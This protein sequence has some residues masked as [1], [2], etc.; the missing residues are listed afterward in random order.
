MVDTLKTHTLLQQVGVAFVCLVYTVN[1]LQD[2][3]SGQLPLSQQKQQQK[4]ATPFDP[5]TLKLTVW[6]RMTGRITVLEGMMR[7]KVH[8]VGAAEMCSSINTAVTHLLLPHNQHDPTALP[9]R[10]SLAS[11]LS[12]LMRIHIHIPALGSLTVQQQYHGL[13]P[14]PLLEELS[15]ALLKNVANVIKSSNLA[16]CAAAEAEVRQSKNSAGS[17]SARAAAVRSDNL[18]GGGVA[19]ITSGLE[20]VTVQRQQLQLQ[21]ILLSSVVQF[22]E[23][24]VW[25]VQSLGSQH[26]ST[27]AWL[28]SVVPDHNSL[29]CGLAELCKHLLGTQ[30][31]SLPDPYVEVGKGF[32][33]HAIKHFHGRLFPGCCHQGCCNLTGASEAALPTLLCGGCRMTRYCSVECQKEAW[34]H[35]GHRFLCGK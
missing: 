10:I 16:M 23:W 9:A 1:Q 6:G 30:V 35:G 31:L 17:T 5:N 28:A 2:G 4:S 24:R 32:G 21:S 3:S 19:Q 29:S 25:P 33:L 13:S 12:K 26:N 27:M 15:T 34:L 7:G 11:T 8:Q 14:D 22:C 20:P 18:T